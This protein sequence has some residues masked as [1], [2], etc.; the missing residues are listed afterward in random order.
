M[1]GDP[2]SAGFVSGIA[3]VEQIEKLG[4]RFENTGDLQFHWLMKKKA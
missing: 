1:Q 4:F 3:L 2:K